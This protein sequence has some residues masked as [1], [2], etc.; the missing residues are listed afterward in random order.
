M[1]IKKKDQ[2][3]IIRGGEKKE[4]KIKRF[5]DDKPNH[6]QRHA[7]YQQEK[8]ATELPTTR[9]KGI[10]WTPPLHVLPKCASTSH[11]PLGV[12]H[13]CLP[14]FFQIQNCS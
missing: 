13:A 7:S 11:A 14:F 4:G 1:P 9:C 10:C 8:D 3:V 12:I 5:T 2:I 6:H